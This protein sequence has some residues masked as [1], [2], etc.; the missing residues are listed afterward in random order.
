MSPLDRCLR[1]PRVFESPAGTVRLGVI[2][3]E[4]DWALL[5]PWWDQLLERTPGATVFQTWTFQQAWWRHC[6]AG[7]QLWIVVVCLE[8]VPVGILPLQLY[9][10]PVSGLGLRTLAFIGFA[11]ESDRPRLL[12][13]PADKAVPGLIAD[14]L[15]ERRDAWDMLWL[16]E[17]APDG[18]LIVELGRSL[19]R[20]H[21]R[22][23][24]GEPEPAYRVR[25]SGTWSQYLAGRTHAL[26]KDLRRKRARISRAGVLRF[27]TVATAG[28][29]DGALE[30]YLAVERASW[31]A[32][33][34]LALA[35]NAAA[36][37]VYR[38]VLGEAAAAGRARFGFLLLDD[39][40]IAATFGLEWQHEYYS[41]HVVHDQRYDACS[42]GVLLT[43]A[44]LAACFEAG[45]IDSV[46]FLTGMPANKRG[47]A[48]G[49]V[50]SQDYR[51]VRASLRGQLFHA[52][53]LRA[54]PRLRL[55]LGRHGWL[56]RWTRLKAALRGR[57]E[58]D[59]D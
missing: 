12:S 30:R 52:V 41:L 25:V 9:R 22:M 58:K 24:R 37:A 6:S 2:D 29:M 26:R 23:W 8:G 43:A 20:P 14:Y 5:E 7:H 47:W 39:T 48:T 13:D 11:P 50:I 32:G 54:K 38:E 3:A 36:L 18:P 28:A 17:Q 4:A 31:K 55:A 40:T 19:A 49:E 42:P 59:A 57:H 56:D 1:R 35:G 27:E 33:T 16:A 53:W 21:W 46:D 51:A 44:E 45:A 10:L 15:A 34:T